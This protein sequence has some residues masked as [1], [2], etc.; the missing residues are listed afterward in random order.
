MQ[1]VF[2]SS[3]ADS[4]L[5]YSELPEF[6]RGL[7]D[8][9]VQEA[10]LTSEAALP[11]DRALA[12]MNP[13]PPQVTNHYKWRATK[14]ALGQLRVPLMDLDSLLVHAVWR[15]PDVTSQDVGRMV[16]TV[17]AQSGYGSVVDFVSDQGKDALVDIVETTFAR[18]ACL[19]EVIRK[20]QET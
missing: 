7:V 15:G 6:A 3:L 18:V 11:F 14:Q 5:A 8:M 16:L 9:R 12:D 10:A 20:Y 17:R 4:Y 1:V 19:R 2:A 13:A